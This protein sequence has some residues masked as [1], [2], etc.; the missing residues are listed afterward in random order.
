M[1]GVARPSYDIYDTPP[2]FRSSPPRSTP[3]AARARPPAQVFC[4]DAPRDRPGSQSPRS[5]RR[6]VRRARGTPRG[7]RHRSSDGRRSSPRSPPR[8]RA[9][10]V[11]AR[12]SCPVSGTTSAPA[13]ASRCSA[14]STSESDSRAA[15]CVWRS[16]Y[17]LIYGQVSTACVR[18]GR[19]NDSLVVSTCTNNRR[20]LRR[21]GVAT[22]EGRTKR[23]IFDAAAKCRSPESLH[24]RLVR[25]ADFLVVERDRR[26]YHARFGAAL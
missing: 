5:R 12:V 21:D 26:R 2:V 18:S 19:L 24:D 15:S 6:L 11:L 14:P 16:R 4:A 22:V 7:C 3:A 23:R 8:R 9:P 25:T 20:P 10:D 13:Q 1:N 17:I